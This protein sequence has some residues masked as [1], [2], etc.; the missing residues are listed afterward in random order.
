[1]TLSPGAWPWLCSAASHAPHN[2]T[3][4]FPR[5]CTT[6]CRDRFRH[7]RNVVMEKMPYHPQL[8]SV[9]PTASPTVPAPAA[10][11]WRSGL[12]PLTGRPVSLRQLRLPHPPTSFPALTR[13]HAPPFTPPPPPPAAPL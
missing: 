9:R 2:P 13:H 10:L 8:D 4:R 11:N 5:R 7:R 3:R 12:P 6:G 1:M